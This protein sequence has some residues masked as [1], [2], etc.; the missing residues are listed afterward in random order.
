MKKLLIFSAGPAGREVYQLITEI[1]KKKRTW[2]VIGYVDDN[3]SSKIKTLDKLKVFSQ[4]NKPISKD[5]YAIT[6]IMNPKSLILE[7]K[8]YTIQI[9]DKH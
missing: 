5:L 1:N 7:I 2:N 4:K 6:G 8:I 3:L 9:V